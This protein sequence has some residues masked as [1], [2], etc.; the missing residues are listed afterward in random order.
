MSADAPGA[1]DHDGGKTVCG[2]ANGGPRGDR[3]LSTDGQDGRSP[4]L[5]KAAGDGLSSVEDKTS[6]AQEAPEE[7]PVLTK[8]ADANADARTMAAAGAGADA[9][10]ILHTQSQHSGVIDAA[11]LN[12]HLS[13]LVYKKETPVSTEPP[14][15]AAEFT[16]RLQPKTKAAQR[17]GQPTIGRAHSRNHIDGNGSHR[18]GEWLGVRSERI[19]AHPC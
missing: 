11:A 19:G 16:R 14:A 17:I 9:A 1:D 15:N 8:A 3:D 10:R 4:E 2:K 5:N 18:L 6:R 13:E 7:A 12:A